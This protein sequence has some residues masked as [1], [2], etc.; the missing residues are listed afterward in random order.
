MPKFVP[1]SRL[2]DCWSSVGN[3]TFYH[4][5]GKC[6]CRSKPAPVFP[7]TM[8]Q[9]EHQSVH[10]R[11]LAAWRTLDQNTQLQWRRRAM[12][13]TAHRPPFSGEGHISGYNLFVSAYHGFATLGDEHIP[14][15]Q[16]FEE[17]PPFWMEHV[18]A[19]VTGSVNLVLRFNLFVGEND[20][21]LRY[22]TLGKIQ[23][24]EA[25]KGCNPGKMQNFLSAETVSV[26]TNPRIVEFSIP[27]YLSFFGGVPQQ[28][29]TCHIRYLLLDTITGYRN[30]YH[31][32]SCSF[33][34]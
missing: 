13:V 18:S 27:E 12:G 21:P 22:R 23:M 25:G 15:P 11:A 9:M 10:L 33:S 30:L 1:N 32:L 7:G 24:V 8:K 2:S 26:S 4:R 14:E 19:E 6:Y 5:D 16:A 29:Y 17:F 31:K 28:E 20:A 3:V 34:L